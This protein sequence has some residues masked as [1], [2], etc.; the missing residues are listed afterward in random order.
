MPNVNWTNEITPI[1]Q[2]ACV[3]IALFA[4]F[5]YVALLAVGFVALGGW[6]LGSVPYACGFAVL[7]LAM[8]ALLYRWLRRRGCAV[9]AAL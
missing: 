7:T 9:F 8:A 4:G 3:T 1:K 2:S 6:K 5:A